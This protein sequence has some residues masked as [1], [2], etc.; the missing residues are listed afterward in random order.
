MKTT[1]EFFFRRRGWVG[2]LLL[3]PTGFLV[4]VSSPHFSEG[5]LMDIAFD[6]G[7]WVLLVACIGLRFWATLYIGGR[8]EKEL[9]T[10]GPY[11]LCRNPLYHGSLCGALSMALF[12]GSYTLLVAVILVAAAYSRLVMPFEERRL[13]E[14]FGE[15]YR[16]YCAA[17]PRLLPRTLKVQAPEQIEVRLEALYGETKRIL[18]VCLIPILAE[19]IAY[20]R[21]APWFPHWYRLP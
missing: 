2:A 10:T 3:I 11:S 20:F 12:L 13:E 15:A 14:V 16:R 19:A 17:T 8:K 7:A 9:V 18:R 5:S 1:S 6:S 21:A 4:I